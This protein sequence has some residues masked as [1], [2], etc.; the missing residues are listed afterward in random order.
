VNNPDHVPDKRLV[1]GGSGTGKTTLAYDQFCKER[2]RLKFVYDHD[3]RF[4][5]RFGP[6]SVSAAGL[7]EAVAAGGVIV[8][9]PSGDFPSNFGA[10]SKD[11]GLGGLSFFCEY[12]MA[13][14]KVARGRKLLWIDELDLVATNTSYPKDLH[15]LMQ[16]GRNYSID[17]F[18]ITGQPNRVHNCI[19]TQCTSVTTFL[20]TA[21]TSMKW[22]VDNGIPADV[23][24]G[25][26]EHGW[27]SRHLRTGATNS[28]VKHREVTDPG[29]DAG[30]VAHG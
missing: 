9:D 23:I 18:L 8:Y 6:E 24:R 14:C 30:A 1:T 10:T 3:G 20:L 26:G 4:S 5:D 16:T 29:A 2:A 27:Y 28:N 7:D 21:E 22:L 13:Q 12:V 11:M 19:L 17:C 25:L 15:V